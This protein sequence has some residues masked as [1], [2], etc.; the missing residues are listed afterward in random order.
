M[1]LRIMLEMFVSVS[2]C[3]SLCMFTVPNALL[4]FKVNIVQVALMLAE[5]S[6]AAEDF[7]RIAG[8]VLTLLINKFENSQIHT[9]PGLRFRLL[10]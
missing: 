5:I 6:S 1:N 10:P 4:M 7:A 8:S 2:L 9:L 3:I